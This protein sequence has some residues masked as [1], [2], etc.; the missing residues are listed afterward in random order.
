M[1]W[2]DTR[3]VPARPSLVCRKWHRASS[4]QDAAEPHGLEPHLA[5]TIYFFQNSRKIPK[6]C[7]QSDAV[8]WGVRTATAPL[9]S[10]HGCGFHEHRQSL[11]CKEGSVTGDMISTWFSLLETATPFRQMPP[12]CPACLLCPALNSP[13]GSPPICGTV[14]H[15]PLT[16]LNLKRHLDAEMEVQRGSLVCPVSHSSY[17][18]RI[19]TQA[20]FLHIQPYSMCETVSLR[21]FE[22]IR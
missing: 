10:E 20:C 6:G 11:H 19:H 4:R 8:W 14:A 18:V 9:Y 5:L 3:P 7:A 1:Q 2:T 17:R 15:H 13:S 22:R 21:A 12:P 16:S